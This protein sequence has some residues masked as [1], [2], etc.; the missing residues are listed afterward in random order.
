MEPSLATS[1]CVFLMPFSSFLSFVMCE[2]VP[3]SMIHSFDFVS[4]GQKD[5]WLLSSLFL[6]VFFFLRNSL[7]LGDW[8][9][10][11]FRI[12]FSPWIA[13]LCAVSWFFASVAFHVLSY[14]TVFIYSFARAR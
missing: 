7:F 11:K 12:L 13:I 4:S 1:V 6:F 5:T 8:F 14:G 10:Y 3:E 9:F 2:V